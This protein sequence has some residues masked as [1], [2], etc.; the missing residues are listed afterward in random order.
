MA[1]DLRSQFKATPLKKLKGKI[2]ED[3][4]ILGGSNEYL[5]LEDGKTVKI[6]IFPAHPGSEDFYI[7][8]KQYWLSVAKDDGDMR[9]TTVLDSVV[10][11]GFA[12][13]IVQEYTKMAKKICVNNT[14]K[15]NAIQGDKDSL[16]P[17]ISWECYASRIVE[18]EPLHPMTWEFKKSVRDALNKLSM[19]EDDSDPIEVD[20]FTDPDEGIPIFV[21]YIKNPNKKKG[22]TWYEVTVGKK[23][24]AY[25]IPDEILEE[26]LKLTPLSELHSKYTMKD[27]D[28]A[29]EG[30]QN[31]DE[32]HEIGLFEDDNW[33]EK[34]E[35]IKAQYESEEDEDDEPKKKTS[36]KT[37]A[38][39]APAKP[40]AKTSKKVVV[41]EPEDDEEDEEAEEDEV[42]EED[43]FDEM[44][45]SELKAYIAEN[46][47]EIPIKKSY[48]EDDI[49]GLIR[50]AIAEPDEEDEAEEDEEEPE[51]V[52]KPKSKV[53]L[54][55]IKK[56][57][58]SK[59]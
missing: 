26:F 31:F 40:A 21:K 36:K 10:H 15:M 24:K 30:L 34:V 12:M 1:K 13:D 22:E 45:R 35:E 5:Q 47:L 54:A 50:A 52:E 55:D 57:M 32:E 7:T 46:E 56:K 44:D 28:R 16:N 9:R 37:S 8:K 51:E 6:R 41:E 11:G 42:A 20:P 4:S 19:S 14:K 39:A 25:V 2:D 27:F 49:R 3:N 58:A 18:G 23:P 17:Q 59:K 43:A 38:K 29:L 33:L 53:S 48:T